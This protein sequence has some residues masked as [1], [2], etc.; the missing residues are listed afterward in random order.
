[1]S[2]TEIGYLG[3]LRS[4]LI[5]CLKDYFFGS[6]KHREMARLWISEGVGLIS[7]S[8]TCSHLGINAEYLQKMIL[9]CPDTDKSRMRNIRKSKWLLSP[10]GQDENIMFP[11]SQG[12]RA[13]GRS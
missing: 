3:I 8:Y 9:R 11:R 12:R 5:Q 10:G 2:D 7:F 13:L 4:L 1:M 6:P